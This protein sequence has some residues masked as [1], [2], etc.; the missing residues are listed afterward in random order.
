MSITSRSLQWLSVTALTYPLGL[1]YSVILARALGPAARGEYAAMLNLG[2]LLCGVLSLGLGVV[3]RAEVARERSLFQVVHT[4]LLAFAF[5]AGA[6]LLVVGAPLCRPLASALNIRSPSLFLAV[7]AVTPL[8]LYSGYWQLLF[9]GAGWFRAINLLRIVRACE[10]PALL[11]LCF[12]MLGANVRAAAATWAVSSLLVLGVSLLFAFRFGGRPRWKGKF[13]YRNTLGHGWRLMVAAQAVGIQMQVAVLLLNRCWPGGDAGHF[14][15]ASALAFQVALL[16]GT[17]AAVVS[18]R[19]AGPDREGAVTLLLF[20]HRL[21]LWSSLLVGVGLALAGRI[22]V[23]ALYGGAFAP[24]GRVLWILAAG[25]VIAQLSEISAQY[26]IGQHRGTKLL[27]LLGLGNAT[28]GLG[29]CALLIPRI[30][31]LGG[32]LAIG[33]GYLANA[34]AY[35]VVL[36]KQLGCPW[37]RLL[38]VNQQDLTRLV[39]AMASVRPRELLA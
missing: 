16:F 14:A 7:L 28:I 24:A 39:A 5:G 34:A 22:I 26:L 19:L 35:A 12:I 23:T 38:L 25:G 8:L 4:R 33:G 21:L 13:S 15:V 18:D 10:E 9:Q 1:L 32:A 30:G 2:A 27:I 6:G 17:V 36:R 20:L 3:G 11:A 31:A 37:Q 29:L